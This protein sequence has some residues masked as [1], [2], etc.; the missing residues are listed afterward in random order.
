MPRRESNPTDNS[1]A[2]DA[3]DAK[4]RREALDESV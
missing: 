4:K 2:S 1:R 3:E